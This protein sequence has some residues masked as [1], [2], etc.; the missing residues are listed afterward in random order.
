LFC[1]PADW[2]RTLN[3]SP[4]GEASHGSD[5]FGGTPK[6]A[7]EDA[8]A[9]QSICIVTAWGMFSKQPGANCNFVEI[10]GLREIGP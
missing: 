7:G 8:R 1:S 9:P 2:R 5:A 6:A 4:L 3:D 10:N